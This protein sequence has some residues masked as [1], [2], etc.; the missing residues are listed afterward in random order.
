MLIVSFLSIGFSASDLHSIC[1]SKFFCLLCFDFGL[2][3]VSWGIVFF[4]LVGPDFVSLGECG[5]VCVL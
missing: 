5:L 3:G 4:W 1:N 2:G